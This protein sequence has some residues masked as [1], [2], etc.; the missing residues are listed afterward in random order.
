MKNL[1]TLVLF[2]A[3]FGSLGAPTYAQLNESKENLPTLSPL[4][5]EE[6]EASTEPEEADNPPANLPSTELFLQ[7]L[8]ADPNPLSRPTLEEE[9]EIEQTQVITLEEAIELAYANNQDLQTT[10]LELEQSQAVLDEAEAAL[11]PTVDM[12]SDTTFQEDQGT[13]LEDGSGIDTFLGSTVEINYDLFAS[14]ARRANIRAAE[15]QVRLDT[16]EV[17]RTQEELRLNTATIYFDL[18]EATED[19]RINQAFVE[20]AAQNLRDNQVRQQAGVGT[21]FDVLRAD[22]QLANARQDLV[23]AR[24]DQQIAQ[25]NLARLL[26]IPTTQNIQATGV[27]R[28]EDWPLTLEESIVLAFQNRVELTQNLEEREIALQQS[29]VARAAVRPQISLFANYSLSDTL[30]DGQDLSDFYSFGADLNWQLF[31]GG[32]AKA[33]ARQQEISAEIAEQ[34]F[35]ETLDT[36]RFD[37]EEAYFNLQANAENIGTAQT[38]VTQARESLNIANLRLDAGVGTEL[39]VLEAQSDLTDAEGNL[40]DALLGYNRALVELQRAVSRLTTTL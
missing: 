6:L 36:I 17:E 37:A 16:L 40:V 13:I 20:E 27:T 15:A 7:D 29:I 12:T 4:P 19:I 3:V 8:L 34:T 1:A 11:L 23:Q 10:L 30:D 35:S 5:S 2:Y 24:S 31:D 38:A 33:S 26:N 22:V 28:A 32:A 25:R 18:Q 9:V 39:D 21:Q 14:G